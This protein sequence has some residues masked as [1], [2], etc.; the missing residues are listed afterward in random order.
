MTHVNKKKL[1][2]KYYNYSDCKNF[3]AC[4]SHQKEKLQSGW[5]ADYYSSAADKGI[6]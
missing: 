4:E 6:Y 2:K 5:I 1:K 3:F